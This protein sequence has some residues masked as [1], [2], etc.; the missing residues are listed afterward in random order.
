MTEIYAQTRNWL[1]SRPNWQQEAAERLLSGTYLSEEDINQLA[2][3]AQTVEGQTPSNHRMFGSLGVDQHANTQLLLTGISDVY[4]MENLKDG[5]SITFQK[6]ALTL[7][8][9]PNGA[10]KSTYTRI[11]R[12]A[13]GAPNAKNLKPNVFEVAPPRQSCVLHYSKSGDVLSTEWVSNATPLADLAPIDVFDSD[14]A[15]N[16]LT[17]RTSSPFTPRL[18]AFF[19]EL[20]NVTDRVK[21]CILQKV[22]ALEATSKL[23]ALPTQF[24]STQIAN[25]LKSLKAESDD[26]AVVNLF[27]WSDAH[28]TEL[29][30]IAARLNTA[31]PAEAAQQKRA[32]RQEVLKLHTTLSALQ[33]SYDTEALTEIRRLRQAAGDARRAASEATQFTTSNF[34]EV[35]SGTWHAMWEAAR[36]FSV[37][38]RPEQAFPMANPGDHCVLCHQPLTVDAASRLQEF[39]RF[40]QGQ[41]ETAAKSAEKA[42][43]DTLNHLPNFHEPDQAVTL[44]RAAGL[45]TQEWQDYLRRILELCQSN[46]AALR[47]H[48]CSS[49]ALDLNAK[50]PIQS[51]SNY[52]TLLDNEAIQLDRDAA[53]FDRTV[54]VRHRTELEARLWASQI[55]PSVFVELARLRQIA[56]L[57]RVA[58]AISTREISIRSGVVGAELI[59]QAYIERFNAELALLN[60]AHIQVELEKKNDKGKISHRI[61]LKNAN[62]NHALESVLSEGE[63]RIVA[64]AAFIANVL[65]RPQ[66]SPF[67]FDDPISSLDHKYEEAVATRL[68]ALANERQVIVLTHRLSLIGAFDES[69]DALGQDWKKSNFHQQS[70]AAFNGKAGIPLEVECW[71][72]NVGTSID[73]LQKRLNRAADLGQTDP[74]IYYQLAQGVCSEYRKL[75]ERCVEDVLLSG[76]VKRHRQSVTTQNKLQFLSAI[77]MR[78]CQFIDEKMSEFSHFEH[79]QSMERAGAVPEPDVMK[80]HLND[81]RV[82]IAAFKQ[83]LKELKSQ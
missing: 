64:L 44:C 6:H 27:V 12:K 25:H 56:D 83:K 35:G 7:V 82:W 24:M 17:Q 11:L 57:K 67:I 81:L 38:V 19:E 36:A 61:R 34:P 39:E 9:G 49:L 18:V 80:S 3:Y 69:A 29:N 26:A 1:L 5:T 66:V 55:L 70:I 13:S 74:G 68:T 28:Q 77:D 40:V 65:D 51:L 16:Y 78:D 30:A 4:G 59:T 31:N 52:I 50:D 79:S 53:G 2:D 76:V 48:E 46:K 63:R 23:P 42:Y 15:T 20:A 33:R 45:E 54:A 37:S 8:F 41:L 47:A 10:G 21:S 75:L 22:T 32:L 71:A 43:L 62:G 60:A 73:L 58:S 14:V 72:T